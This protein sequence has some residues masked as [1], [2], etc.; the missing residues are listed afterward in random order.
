MKTQTD[1]L[2]LLLHFK[3]LNSLIQTQTYKTAFYDILINGLSGLIK[4]LL[5]RRQLTFPFCC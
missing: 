1:K 2:K 4:T 5:Y 3:G